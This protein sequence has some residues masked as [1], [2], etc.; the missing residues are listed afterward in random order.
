MSKIAILA[1]V[2]FALAA[3][4]APNAAAK[5]QYMKAV[6]SEAPKPAASAPAKSSKKE[7]KI[8]TRCTTPGG[9]TSSAC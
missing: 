1:V 6:P 9:K 7:P 3:W 5:D 8:T 2:L 4:Q